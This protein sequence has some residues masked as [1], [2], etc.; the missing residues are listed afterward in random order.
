MQRHALT[1]MPNERDLKKLACKQHQGVAAR[2]WP[3]PLITALQRP[4]GS[5][6]PHRFSSDDQGVLEASEAHLLLLLLLLWPASGAA[7]APRRPPAAALTSA[8]AAS[9]PTRRAK[10]QLLSGPCRMQDQ[11]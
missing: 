5:R 8:A 1:R 2:Q 4:Q 10:L 9:Q 6:R 3:V 7:G 11:C